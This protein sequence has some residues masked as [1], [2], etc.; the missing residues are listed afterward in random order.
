MFRRVRLLA[1]RLAFATLIAVAPTLP[2]WQG[3]VAEAAPRF[4]TAAT[5]ETRLDPHLQAYLA[6][7]PSRMTVVPVRPVNGTVRARGVAQPAGV[8]VLIE[9]TRDIRADLRTLGANARTRA[10]RSGI[11]TATVPLNAL[12]AVANLAGVIKVTASMPTRPSLDDSLVDAKI[13]DGNAVRPTVTGSTTADGDG[14]LVAIVDSGIDLAHDDFKDGGATRIDAVWDQTGGGSGPGAITGGS[15]PIDDMGYGT[16][17]TAAEIDAASCAQTD[18]TGHGTHVASIAA[19][20]SGAAPASRLLVVKH[21]GT[22]VGAVDAWAWIIAKASELGKPVVINNSWGSHNGAHDGTAVEERA[23]DDFAQL[24]GVAFVVAAGDDGNKAIHA[25]SGT[26]PV[27]IGGTKSVAFVP[28]STSASINFWYSGDDNFSISLMHNGTQTAK[29]IKGGRTRSYSLAG[30]TIS[31]SNCV[32]ASTSNNL[33]QATVTLTGMTPADQDWS[34]ELDRT[35]LARASSTGTWDAW[36]T[37]DNATFTVP[38]YRTTLAEPATASGAISVG[39]FV[40]DGSMTGTYSAFSALGPTRDSRAKPDLL[41]PGESIIAAQ[42]GTTNGTTAKQG[43]SMAAPHVAGIVA[44]MY[45]KNAGY[46]QSQIRDALLGTSTSAHTYG[47]GTSTGV[48]SEDQ[49]TLAPNASGNSGRPAWNNRW[50]YGKVDAKKAVDSVTYDPT[51]AT[52]TPTA[53]SVPQP[54]STATS[55]ASAT[56][57]AGASATSTASSTATSTASSTPTVSGSASATR[58]STS[59]ITPNPAFSAT[60]SPTSTASST[61]TVTPNPAFSATASPSSTASGTSTSTIT[62]N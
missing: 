13:V 18:T 14:T 51:G 29:A 45:Q 2:V 49:V 62:P 43:T 10:S 21:D 16:V 33:C 24:S 15:R 46:T 27:A 28:T 56:S 19:G 23:L 42:S 22:T 17:C 60:A 9:A 11:Y 50:G 58:T 30:A 8:N 53:S 41:A 7:S 48:A 47:Y 37:T 40:A 32:S 38:S 59:T 55:P 35:S 5:T 20:N 61:S 34:V 4:Q 36:V 31:I 52:A 6:G 3:G 54:T 1:S 39:S 57:T 25:R 44:M 26:A 12:Q